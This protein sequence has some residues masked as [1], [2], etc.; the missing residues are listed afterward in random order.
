MKKP[1]KNREKEQNQIFGLSDSSGRKSYYPEL[2]SRN[3]ELERFR[4]LLDKTSDAFLVIDIESGKIIDANSSAKKIFKLEDNDIDL[5]YFDQVFPNADI[6]LKDGKE[7]MFTKKIGWRYVEVKMDFEKTGSNAYAIAVVRDISE[8]MEAQNLISE[9]ERRF[10][11][12]FQQSLHLIGLISI[13]GRIIDINNTALN[14]IGANMSDLLGMKFWEAP[15]WN[16]SEELQTKLQELIKKA[17]KGEI[18]YSEAVHY[19]TNGNAVNIDFSIKPFRSPEGE[20]LFLIA[21]GRN[22]TRLKTALNR[23]SDINKELNEKKDELE[24]IIYVTS[25]DFRTPLINIKG[26]STELQK[27][28]EELLNDLNEIDEKD[29]FNSKVEYYKSDIF[30]Y[31]DTILKNSNKMNIML[32][33]LSKVLRQNNYVPEF[34]EVNLNRIINQVIET[35]EKELR[36]KGIELKY[37]NLPSYFGD[38]LQFNSLFENLISNAIK[39]HDGSKKSYIKIYSEE[40]ADKI[41]YIVEDNG[42]GIE[43]KYFDKIFEMFYRISDDSILGDGLGLSLVRKIVN[44]LKGQV[45]VESE[46]GKWTKFIVELPIETKFKNLQSQ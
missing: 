43:D 35:N 9:K 41:R 21:E 18:V 37:E 26:F 25:H 22:V 12:L 33:G 39:Y 11:A 23:L 46:F 32:N 13:E 24:Q 4:L 15:W 14:L 36:Q 31:T 5:V 7:T 40:Q 42:L 34:E 28:V 30:E 2:K 8:R 38:K 16:H 45:F 44:N 1:S 19:D 20:I 27:T 17:A 10:N 6:N 29:N 3:E